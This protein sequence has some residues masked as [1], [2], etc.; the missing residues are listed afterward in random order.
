[1]VE[2][3]TGDR[4]RGQRS[5]GMVRKGGKGRR[6]RN[7]WRREDAH[8]EI[9]VLVPPTPT[10]RLRVVE[11]HAGEP[12]IPTA[13]WE[14]R[15]KMYWSLCKDLI[16]FENEDEDEG[17]KWSNAAYRKGKEDG[18]ETYSC[19]CVA[20]IRSEV[21]LA[22]GAGEEKREVE[23]RD[24]Q[25][26]E[27]PRRW[28]SEE[29]QE[30]RTKGCTERR[31]MQ[32]V[33]T[34]GGETKEEQKTTPNAK[35]GST[36]G[37]EAR[38]NRESDDRWGTQISNYALSRWTTDLM[39]RC[40]AFSDLPPSWIHS[41][42]VVWSTVEPGLHAMVSHRVEEGRRGNEGEKGREDVREVIDPQTERFIPLEVVEEPKIQR[43]LGRG[44]DRG[45][46]GY[47]DRVALV[48][49]RSTRER[50]R[51]GHTDPDSSDS[52]GNPHG[53]VSPHT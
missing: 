52:Q 33:R 35:R 37:T 20:C 26:G 47:G 45:W 23:R 32:G 41:S 10:Q 16:K 1:M 22:G 11:V 30:A 5:A 9:L 24:K 39:A 18:D 36:S 27:G 42:R 13:F 14:G 40:A 15:D 34:K 29:T 46:M 7:R 31:D 50:Q 49:G 38:P 12:A 6:P 4:E 53:D 51:M 8:P 2:K 43:C 48:R 17:G 3:T 21:W 25:G 28:K 19:V 44:M